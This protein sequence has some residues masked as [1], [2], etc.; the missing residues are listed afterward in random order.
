MSKRFQNNIRQAI[1][2]DLEPLVALART[3]FWHTY[4]AYNTPENMAAYM[5]SK[6]TLAAFAEL[7]ADTDTSIFVAYNNTK[8][9]ENLLG[10]IQL[11]ND[12]ACPRLPASTPDNTVQLSRLYVAQNQQGKGLGT[13]L[14]RYALGQ[15]IGQGVSYWWLTVWQKNQK[16]IDFYTFLDFET[17]GTTTFT[18]GDDVQ[19]DWVMYQKIV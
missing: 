19:T 14:L 11:Q 5:D 17:A 3:T 9:K 7:L 1:A 15:A 18:V 10:Y 4:H 16:A 6:L 13:Q 12:L 2:T 8:D